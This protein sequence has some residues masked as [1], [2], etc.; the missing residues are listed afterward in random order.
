[1]EVAVTETIPDDRALPM[2]KRATAGMSD[3]VTAGRPRSP[4]AAERSQEVEPCS[5]A[6]RE[7]IELYFSTPPERW[8]APFMPYRPWRP[9]AGATLQCHSKLREFAPNAAIS[10]GGSHRWDLPC[11]RWNTV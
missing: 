9:W 8:R 7:A 1:L 6:C 3:F 10:A 2:T 11:H 4:N 5:G